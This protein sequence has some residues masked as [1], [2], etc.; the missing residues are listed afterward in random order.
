MITKGFVIQST[1]TRSRVE[2][3]EGTEETHGWGWLLEV[4]CQVG[5]I[6]AVSEHY[7]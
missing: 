2:V 6:S 1:R 3:L 4:T 5:S 7:H